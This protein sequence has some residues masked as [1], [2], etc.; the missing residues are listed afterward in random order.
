MYGADRCGILSTASGE[1]FAV[2][3]WYPRLCVFDDVQ[4]WN[5]EPY[6]GPS[7]FY[8]EYGDFDVSI[9]APA[10]LLVLAGG[11][12]TNAREVLSTGQMQRL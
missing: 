8:L 12:L 6:L 7:E 4:G 10:R 5:T 3:Q 2:A 11:E 9:T 1:I